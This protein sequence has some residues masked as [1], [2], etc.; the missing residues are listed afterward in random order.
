MIDWMGGFPAPKAVLTRL[1]CKYSLVQAAKLHLPDE[2]NV[3][4]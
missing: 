1:A 4:T 3:P 2:W